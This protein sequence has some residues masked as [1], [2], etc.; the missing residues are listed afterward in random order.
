[1]RGVEKGSVNGFFESPKGHPRDQIVLSPSMNIPKE[2][3]YIGLNGFGFL[4]KPGVEIDIPRP[5]RKM[6]DTLIITE[7]LQ[8]DQNRW[9][10]RDIPRFPYTLVTENVDPVNTAKEDLPVENQ[11]NGDPF[12]G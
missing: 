7:T 8:D 5:V 10:T 9:Y 6:L 2:G 3:Q 1:M 4:A 12:G 11:T